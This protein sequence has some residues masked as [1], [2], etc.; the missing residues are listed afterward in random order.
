M[1]AL[2]RLITVLRERSTVTDTNPPRGWVVLLAPD[3]SHLAYLPL[4]AP[5]I[6][7]LAED[8]GLDTTGES[9]DADLLWD[10]LDD[11]APPTLLT[12]D[13][14]AL[15]RVHDGTSTVDEIRLT[16]TELTDLATLL[17]D[18][19]RRRAEREQLHADHPE[20]VAEVTAIA[21]WPEDELS[22]DITA[23]AA[24]PEDE[25]AAEIEDLAPRSQSDIC[26]LYAEVLAHGRRVAATRALDDWFGA[27]TDPSDEDPR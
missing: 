20:L 10:A 7:Q 9:A 23:I 14:T 15:L 26:V 21:A 16:D 13:W 8:C 1:N 2:D 19:A 6:L 22:A 27:V 18:S 25:L 5:D 17:D 12:G 11:A 24:W 4:A 3:G